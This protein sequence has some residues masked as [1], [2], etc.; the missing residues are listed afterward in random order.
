MAAFG[1]RHREK[2]LPEYPR[3]QLQQI[4][5]Q[6]KSDARSTVHR[7]TTPP[8]QRFPEGGDHSVPPDVLD[9]LDRARS[10][11]L[12]GSSIKQLYENNRDRIPPSIREWGAEM[13]IDVVPSGSRV[14]S[15]AANVLYR[16]VNITE[17]D[18]VPFFALVVYYSGLTSGE[19]KTIRR[20]SLEIT[21]VGIR[22][23][24]F[25]DRSHTGREIVL[26][27]DTNRTL[28][29]VLEDAERVTR[30][31]PEASLDHPASDLLWSCFYLSNGRRHIKPAEFHKFS[32]G[33]WMTL[34]GLTLPGPHKFDRLRK[35]HKSVR[36]QASA[37]LHGAVVDHSEQVFLR[38]YVSTDTLLRRSAGVVSAAQRDIFDKVISRGPT[39][40]PSALQNDHDTSPE[41][42]TLA[43]QRDE[44][45]SLDRSLNVGI[46]AA[47]EDEPWVKNGTCV[48]PVA[49]CMVCR[50][51]VIFAE[52][53]P[54]VIVLEQHLEQ[55][56]LDMEP[57]DFLERYGAS[58]SNA[59][60]VISMFPQ[61]AVLTANEKL[62]RTEERLL[63][64]LEMHK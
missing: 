55:L 31:V 60:E 40:I 8:A 54:Q 17:L 51:S 59:R 27:R 26:D 14:W 34:R 37:G 43:Q 21:E 41:I 24:V 16:Y 2:N 64:P 7:L 4:L 42:R 45:S 44:Q 12:Q 19:L 29:S 39:V 49:K 13:G 35:N 25:K 5:K 30:S 23:E 62:A 36:T 48:D 18:L 28:C 1:D 9:L 57:A 53:L 46:C 47:R 22:F 61:N 3:D 63:V 11:V 6:A 50:N 10:G 52:H 58:L 38:H 15:T 56:R 32:I 20:S 33:H